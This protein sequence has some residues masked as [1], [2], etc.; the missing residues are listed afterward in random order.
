MA[1]YEM[2]NKEP[3]DLSRQDERVNAHHLLLGGGYSSA[4][5]SVGQINIALLYNVID[6]D[7]SIYQFGTFGSFPLFLNVSLGFGINKR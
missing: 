7:E 5:G 2:A 3:Y 4:I 1:Q 6:S